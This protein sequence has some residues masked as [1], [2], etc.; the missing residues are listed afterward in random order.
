MKKLS[1]QW[2]LNSQK[3]RFRLLS[4]FA[5]M[6]VLPL[7]IFAQQLFSLN[8]PDT[9]PSL[10]LLVAVILSLLGLYLMVGIL[11]PISKVV[12]G[13]K[14]LARGVFIPNF[15][16]KR[17]DEIGELEDA[18]NKTGK[19]LR[20]SLNELKIHEQRT[21]SL[22]RE[23]RELLTKIESLSITDDLTGL[24]NKKYLKESLSKE[25]QR[26][27]ADQRPC[28]LAVFYINDFK[29][30]NDTC[31][32]S[33]GDSV[34]KEVA[35]LILN[36]TRDV[37]KAARLGGGRFVVILPDKNKQEALEFSGR[38]KERVEKHH[39]PHQE[40]LPGGNL[41]VSAGVASTPIDGITGEKLLKKAVAVLN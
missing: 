15:E 35:R 29:N 24:Y 17:K 8:L 25:I 28:S 14:A 6:S 13:A 33:G 11:K 41:T 9:T 37:D 7:L 32:E 31:G 38:V 40:S 3:L 4:A 18:L 26:A 36:A 39:F 2:S 5:L 30:Y 20:K 19:G 23:I 21:E 34:L 22:N 12:A 1:F 10:L 27:I 16:L